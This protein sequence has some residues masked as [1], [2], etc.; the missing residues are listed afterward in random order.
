MVKVGLLA[1]ALGMLS[2]SCCP[3]LTLI[4]CSENVAAGVRTAS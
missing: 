3:H 4:H 1:A 2:F